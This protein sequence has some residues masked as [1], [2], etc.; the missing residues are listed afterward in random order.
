MMLTWAN[1]K[2]GNCAFFRAEDQVSNHQAEHD[3]ICA[4]NAA[5]SADLTSSTYR[6]GDHRTEAEVDANIRARALRA[7][8]AEKDEAVANNCLAT[9]ASAKGQ[10]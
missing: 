7:F 6:C 4:A 3:G 10:V 1:R 5:S 2:C 8:Q 9:W